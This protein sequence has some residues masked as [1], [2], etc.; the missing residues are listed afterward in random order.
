MNYNSRDHGH[1]SVHLAPHPFDK[2]LKQCESELPRRTQRT[3][4]GARF[5]REMPSIKTRSF[6]EQAI[7]F[8]VAVLEKR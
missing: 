2:T 3:A 6:M 4:H 8:C 7:R 1:I 5:I